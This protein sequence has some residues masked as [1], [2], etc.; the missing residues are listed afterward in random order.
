[1]LCKTEKATLAE[2]KRKS[3]SKEKKSA[4]KSELQRRK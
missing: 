3:E 1:V 2:K 4:S